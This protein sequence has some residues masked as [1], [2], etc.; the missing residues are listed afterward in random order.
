MFFDKKYRMEE[1]EHSQFRESELRPTL[2]I[3]VTEIQEKNQIELLGKRNLKRKEGLLVSI[4]NSMGFH[5]SV[6]VKVARKE[7]PP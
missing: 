4:S 2:K 7:V 6:F 1:R 3:Q 5:F